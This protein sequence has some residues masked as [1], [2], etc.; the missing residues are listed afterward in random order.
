MYSLAQRLAIPTVYER[1][2]VCRCA[3]RGRIYH[4]SFGSWWVAPVAR[5]ASRGPKSFFE[6]AMTRGSGT[7]N[8]LEPNNELCPLAVCAVTSHLNFNFH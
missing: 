7:I 6:Y 5:K 1:D 3:T 2:G 8:G 4:L